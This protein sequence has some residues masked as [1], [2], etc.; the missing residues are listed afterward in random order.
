MAAEGPRVA[1]LAGAGERAPAET[2]LAQVEA[3]LSS[4]P[5]VILLETG[6]GLLE[7][8]KALKVEAAPIPNTRL[9]EA[10]RFRQDFLVLHA[11]RDF[12]KALAVASC[13]AIAHLIILRPLKFRAEPA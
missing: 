7:L 1:I 6:G 4:D 2:A 13:S 5:G 3:G 12:F 8:R 9:I 11:Q 10:K